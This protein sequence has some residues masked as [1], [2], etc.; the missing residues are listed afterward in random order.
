MAASAADS[1]V[2]FVESSLGA[3]RGGGGGG[4]L[5]TAFA[6]VAAICARVLERSLRRDGCCGS[7]AVF[8]AASGISSTYPPA[9]TKR[10]TSTARVCT[11]RQRPIEYARKSP[12]YVPP[13]GLRRLVT[14]IDHGHDARGSLD[15]KGED[16]TE[17]V[18]ERAGRP[19]L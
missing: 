2:S 8:L 4:G 10:E 14:A 1:T 11:L 13:Q 19:Q 15:I 7:G 12:T 18:D 6:K 5:A 3:R 17:T 9:I 16:G